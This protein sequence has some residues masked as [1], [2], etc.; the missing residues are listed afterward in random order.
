MKM[1]VAEIRAAGPD[2]EAEGVFVVDQKTLGSTRAGKPFLTVGLTDG[3]GSIE[4][5]VWDRA[6][7]LSQSFDV[8]DMVVVSGRSNEFQG[9]VQ[10]KVHSLE[11]APEGEYDPAGFMPVSRFLRD[12]M[13]RELWEL[14]DE[15][16]HPFLSALLREIFND[17]DYAQDFI[18]APAA[19]NFHHSCIGGLLEHTLSVA[20][21]AL[22]MAEHYAEV[23][24]DL[25]LTGALVHDIGKI[26]EYE[27]SRRID[28]S[29]CGRLMGHIALGVQL[30]SRSADDVDGFPEELLDMVCHLILSHHGEP[31]FGSPVR[32]A[33]LEAMI[34]HHIDDLDAKVEARRQ[35]IEHHPPQGEHW[36]PYNRLLERFFY[37][38][39]D[40]MTAEPE[41]DD[42]VEE[43]PADEP[44]A[45]P[46][47]DQQP[48]F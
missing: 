3:T 38:G 21:L 13:W 4:G 18:N 20:R 30:V 33:T 42:D 39:P 5:K 45:E 32:P 1:T 43:S 23:N 37:V 29:D 34:L 14:I 28:F 31:Q 9:K 27:F 36:S 35:F 16:E 10:I 7:E 2:S 6:E 19:K 48:L 22:G 15:M 12:D 17:P 40:P 44:P 24:R 26:Y 25:L 8:D 11:V 46:D 41:A 47:D